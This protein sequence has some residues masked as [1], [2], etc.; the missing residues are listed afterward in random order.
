MSCDHRPVQG[1]VLTLFPFISWKKYYRN[2]QIGLI[3][4]NVFPGAQLPVY[5]L[6]EGSP[7]LDVETGASNTHGS[8]Q[9]ITPKGRLWNA[10]LEARRCS[11]WTSLLMFS[12]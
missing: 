9:E 6:F 5:F 11:V 3:S 12:E 8:K 7:L 2:K 4:L 1:A 10:F